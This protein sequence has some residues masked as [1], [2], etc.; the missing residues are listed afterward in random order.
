MPVV[1]GEA[2]GQGVDGRAPERR[3]RDTLVVL[4]GITTGVADATAFLALGKVFSSVM[5]GNLVLLGVGA[6]SRDP[7]EALRAGLAIAGYVAGV[8]AGVPIAARPGR[9]RAWPVGVTVTLAAEACVLL[10]FAAVW[11]LTTRRGAAS[12]ALLLLLAA[13][14]GMQAAAVQ[15]LGQMSSTYLTGTLT[16]VIAGLVTRRRSPGRARDIGVMV[17]VI[18]GALAGGLLVRF[19]PGWV[20]VPL[21]LPLLVVIGSAAISR[22]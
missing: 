20:P 22:A 5:T 11:E 10:T 3:L 12:I 14:M 17:A 8:L 9:R 2:D 7:R 4:L 21:L 15:R 13:A 1:T 18:A 19:G 16:S 6:A